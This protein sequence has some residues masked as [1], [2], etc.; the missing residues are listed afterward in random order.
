MTFLAKTAIAVALAATLAVG[1]VAAQQQP[2][3]AGPM[4]ETGPSVLSTTLLV[5]D[6][7]RAIDFYQRLGLTKAI[8]KT[9]TASDQGGVVGVSD[10][11]L[12]SDPTVGRMVMMRGGTGRF[13]AIGL[14]AYDKPKLANA[15]GNLA[16]LGTG[17][18]VIAIEVADIQ[19]VYKRLG[20]IGTRFHRTPTR[21][22]AMDPDGTAVTGQ[23]MF[24]FDPDGHLVEITARDKK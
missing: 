4:P 10:L 3:T 24:A 22:N 8:D 21:F 14:L 18:V 6:L 1:G 5:E 7:G 11:P 20:Q 17:D 2:R 12:T 23:R 13:G 19:E 16:G 15:R 9:T